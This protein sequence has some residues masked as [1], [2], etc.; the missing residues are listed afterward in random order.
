MTKG[1]VITQNSNSASPVK[2]NLQDSIEN[3]GNVS[4]GNTD[5]D[6]SDSD[7]QRPKKKKEKKYY[8]RKNALCYVCTVCKT[9]FATNALLEAH[10]KYDHDGRDSFKCS[11]CN[12][13]FT[14]NRNLKSHVEIVH[15]G[16]KPWK[17]SECSPEGAHNSSFSSHSGLQIHLKNKHGK[18]NDE[19]Q[20]LVEEQM[21]FKCEECNRGF[22]NGKQ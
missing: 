10:L 14:Q 19:A 6:A 12:M 17:C 16:K 21:S 20:E 7:C 5:G 2:N 4:I 8:D 1:T 9:F 11:F 18:N 15:E 13:R 22:T 3:V